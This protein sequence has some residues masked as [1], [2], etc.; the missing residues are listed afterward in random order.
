MAEEDLAAARSKVHI[1]FDTWTSPN[2]K[3]AM[4]GI[5]T[6]YL[7]M[8]LTSRSIFI[9]L[10]K[11]SGSHS[12]ENMGAQVVKMLREFGIEQHIGYFI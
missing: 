4:L 11:V 6:H 1:S 12:G 3:L 8:N 2:K 5:V 7:D 10:K 9:G